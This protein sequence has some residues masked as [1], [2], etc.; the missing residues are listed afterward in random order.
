MTNGHSGGDNGAGKPTDSRAVPGAADDSGPGGT[1]EAMDA[2]PLDA[3]LE[4]AAS[5]AASQSLEFDAASLSGEPTP[6]VQANSALSANASAGAGPAD[7]VPALPGLSLIH[8]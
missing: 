3:V 8:I 1:P 6:R 7:R 5:Q 2:T 4:A